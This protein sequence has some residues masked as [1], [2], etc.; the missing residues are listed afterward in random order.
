MNEFKKI[1]RLFGLLF[2]L[3]NIDAV[4]FAGKKN[5]LAKKKT[6]KNISNKPSPVIKSNSDDEYAPGISDADLLCLAKKVSQNDEK[7]EVEKPSYLIDLGERDFPADQPLITYGTKVFNMESISISVP[8]FNETLKKVSEEVAPGEK[9]VLGDATVFGISNVPRLFVDKGDG[10]PVSFSDEDYD[11]RADL[12]HSCFVSNE[13]FNVFGFCK[14]VSMV[15]RKNNLVE[16]CYQINAFGELLYRG[17]KKLGFFELIVK[18]QNKFCFHRI[19]KPLEGVLFSILD[20]T[21]A[22]SCQDK[23]VI[24]LAL[25]SLN[26]HIALL[27]E[28]SLDLPFYKNGLVLLTDILSRLN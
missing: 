7:K 18:K 2:L 8:K 22:E 6:S 11:E 25:N 9:I 20:G 13:T 28:G 19:F 14:M 12:F 3:S 24:E 10:K 23:R 27:P 17:I 26:K 16:D 21:F 1:L 5:P 15:N 4:V